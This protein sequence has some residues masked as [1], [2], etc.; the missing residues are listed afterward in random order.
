MSWDESN[1]QKRAFRDNEDL[2]DM[3]YTGKKKKKVEKH[4]SLERHQASNNGRWI[5]RSWKPIKKYETPEEA[6]AALDR[7]V[8]NH[9]GEDKTIFATRFVPYDINRKQGDT[10]YAATVSFEGNP[11][12]YYR[13]IYTKR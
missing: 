1:Y 6:K 9:K 4:Y 3:P 11:Y 7:I 12:A 13:I 8:E 5:Y 2:D 10:I